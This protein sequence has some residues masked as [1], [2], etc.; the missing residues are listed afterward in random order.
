MMRV[1]NGYVERIVG[2]KNHSRNDKSG[3]R[4]WWLVKYSGNG[5]SGYICNVKKRCAITVPLRYVGK[6]VRL[7]IEV[8]E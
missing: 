1:R 5:G 7:K 8:I 2:G 6:R 3:W 4:L